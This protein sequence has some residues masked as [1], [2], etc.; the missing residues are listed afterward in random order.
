MSDNQ[1]YNGW[2]NW[3]TWATSLSMLNE[4]HTYKYW[5]SAARTFDDRDSLGDR[6]SMAVPRSGVVVDDVDWSEVD[7]CEVADAFIEAAED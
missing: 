3:D 5:L 2:A 1:E 7:W 6:M 4:E